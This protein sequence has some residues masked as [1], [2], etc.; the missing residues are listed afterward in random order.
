M[1]T[2]TADT[3]MRMVVAS[4][5]NGN[6]F[7][8]DFGGVDGNITGDDPNWDTFVPIYTAD[9]DSPVPEPASYGL[10]ISVFAGMFVFSRRQR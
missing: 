6:N 2:I 1:N 5:T 8:Q 4:S 10:I 9:G 3:E 7:N